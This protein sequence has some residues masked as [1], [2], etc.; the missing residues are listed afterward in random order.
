MGHYTSVVSQKSLYIRKFENFLL[1][2]PE[3]VIGN[4]FIFEN[5]GTWIPAFAG[6]TANTLKHM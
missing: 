4:P 6:M 5:K 1:V 2:I 3:V